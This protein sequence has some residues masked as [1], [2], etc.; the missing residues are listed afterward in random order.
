MGKRPLGQG[1]GPTGPCLP[2]TPT[3][4]E[5]VKAQGHAKVV[6]SITET[7]RRTLTGWRRGPEQPV[8]F[9]GHASEHRHAAADRALSTSMSFCC[10]SGNPTIC[11]SCPYTHL[12]FSLGGY[13]PLCL[14]WLPT[15]LEKST[16]DGIAPFL[17]LCLAEGHKRKQTLTYTVGKEEGQRFFGQKEVCK[18]SNTGQFWA[19][20]WAFSWQIEGGRYK[21]RRRNSPIIEHKQSCTSFS[22]G[23]AALKAVPGVRGKTIMYCS[24]LPMAV[25]NLFTCLTLI[26][27]T[28]Q[29]TLV[30]SELDS[31]FF[32]TAQHQGREDTKYLLVNQLTSETNRATGANKFPRQDRVSGSIH[33]SGFCSLSW[34][35]QNSPRRA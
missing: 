21:A 1:V 30:V 32:A 28:V 33:P 4:I 13:S 19:K 26:L 6:I 15:D 10:V 34:R 5:I 18:C 7:P 11:P 31:E 2:R 27:S 14:T 25:L 22:M 3:G 16:K 35:W 8:P 29:D 17:G 9:I 12:L 20:A 24:H 23:G